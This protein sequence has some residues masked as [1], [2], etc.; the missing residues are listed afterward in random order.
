MKKLLLL[1]ALSCLAVL[2]SARADDVALLTL[3]I[4]KDP[5]PRLVALEFYEGDAPRAVENFKKLAKQG[6][7]KGIAFHRAFDFL[8]V[9]GSAGH[10]GWL[11]RSCA[12]Q[13]AS[14]APSVQVDGAA[15]DMHLALGID[16]KIGF[17]LDAQCAIGLQR[18]GLVR[19]HR[20]IGAGDVDILRCLH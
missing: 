15:L 2:T 18:H 13:E 7:Y 20:E 5:T 1:S 17:T 11:C 3:E 6:F 4:G 8:A 19:T 12:R 10:R 16:M 9:V 14:W